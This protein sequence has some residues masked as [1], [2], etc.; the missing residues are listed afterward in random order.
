[1]LLEEC[2]ETSNRTRQEGT[3]DSEDD[4]AAVKISIQRRQKNDAR[5]VAAASKV[6]VV[7]MQA[8]AGN[9]GGALLSSTSQPCP[10]LLSHLTRSILH[11]TMVS[12]QHESRVQFWSSEAI[13]LRFGR[14]SFRQVVTSKLT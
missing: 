3:Q 12:K 9:A 5:G 8:G 10:L 7:A 4:E 11:G 13:V 6:V 1:V 14:M 2:A